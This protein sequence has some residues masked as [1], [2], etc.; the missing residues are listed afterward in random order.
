MKSLKNLNA[1]GKRVLV[2]ADFNISDFSSDE[3]RLTRAIPTLRYLVESR[4]KVI[5]LTHAETNDGRIP[6]LAPLA[7][8]LQKKYFKNLVFCPAVVGPNAQAHVGKMKNGDILLLE[9]VRT[10]RGEKAADKK[11]AAS[12][13]SL[14]DVYVN[15][16]F[17]VSHRRHASIVLLPGLLPAYPGFLFRSEIE[18]LSRAFRP[19]HPFVAVLGGG[20]IETK[21]PLVKKFSREAD[22]VI[23][24]G[25]P[26]N[27]FLQK[28]VPRGNIILPHDGVVR[29]HGKKK[30]YPVEKVRDKMKIWDA[31]SESLSYWGEIIARARFVVWNGPLGFIEKGFTEG[32]AHM[33][34]FLKKSHARVIIG[35]GDTL[36]CLPERIPKHIFVS[37]GGGAMLEFLAEET[38]PG[39]E[40]LQRRA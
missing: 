23:L 18:H 1:R 39:I 9:N 19:P 20:K 40:A 16:A 34:T 7:C 32:T 11:F 15:E 30:T 27:V 12:L 10:R 17:S 24:G 5:V 13:A 3:I 14:G 33:Y 38:L 4:A 22:Q 2:R 37:T 31:G 21:L 6:S 8:H 25:I 36:S 26:A 28:S 35:G 29:E